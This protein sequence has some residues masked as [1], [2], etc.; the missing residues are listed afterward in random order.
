MILWLVLLS[1][2]KDWS[3]LTAARFVCAL[4]SEGSTV[5]SPVAVRGEVGEAGIPNA[6]G[7]RSL[8]DSGNIIC[9]L[10]EDD[11]PRCGGFRQFGKPPETP[12]TMISA[13]NSH[14]CG[15]GLDGI[16]VCW[17][18]N[19]QG[20]TVNPGK[21]TFRSIYSGDNRNCGQHRDDTNW[22]CWGAN[23]TE[24]H[25]GVQFV[26][27][28][29]GTQLISANISTVEL[30]GVKADG[31]LAYYG[32]G[33]PYD[34]LAQFPSGGGYT[35][36]DVGIW[37]ACALHESGRIDCWGAL[38][39]GQGDVPTPH[40]YIDMAAGDLFT[41]G[42]HADGRVECWGCNGECL[43]TWPDVP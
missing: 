9:A 1:C 34:Q 29:P 35:R 19:Y 10:D 17:G 5:C 13:G 4:D 37:H 2:S 36:V 40:D 31:T 39:A 15:L 27:I 11:L 42:R 6:T 21:Q 12:M 26:D 28:E 41:C 24:E 43:E 38:G 32:L 20:E 22:T 16:P 23:G 8:S 18:S 33:A 14:G 30:L 3:P 25:L 7:L